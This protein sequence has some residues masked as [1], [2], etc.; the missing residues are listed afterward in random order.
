MHYFHLFYEALRPAEDASAAHLRTVTAAGTAGKLELPHEPVRLEL[1]GG[2]NPRVAR[3]ADP[4]VGRSV[5]LEPILTRS[6]HARLLVVSAGDGAFT[7]NGESA[8]R[9]A[10]LKELD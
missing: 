3:L 10:L 2:N 7:V 9:I 6:H 8:P 4:S 1:H 5:V